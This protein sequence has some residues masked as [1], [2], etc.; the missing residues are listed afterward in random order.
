M[1]KS[2]AISGFRCEV[3]ENRAALCY[4]AESSGNFLPN[5][6]DNLSVPKRL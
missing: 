2:R 5:F 1:N 3:D 6:S 4:Y